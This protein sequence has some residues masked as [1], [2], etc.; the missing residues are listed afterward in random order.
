MV[1]DKV[2]IQLSQ[3]LNSIIRKT[4]YLFRIGGDEFSV[5]FTNCIIEDVKKLAHR[6]GE[7]A[8][9]YNFSTGLNQF[10]IKVSVGFAIIKITDTASDLIIRA[11]Q[12]MYETKSENKNQFAKSENKNQFAN[13]V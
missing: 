10:H 8:E 13:I 11:D 1:G 6:M 12:S 3:I 2:L 9:N 5:I 4:D 7:I